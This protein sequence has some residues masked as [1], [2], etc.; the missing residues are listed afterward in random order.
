MAAR[1]GYL[2]E[3]IPGV[4]DITDQLRAPMKKNLLKTWAVAFREDVLPNLSVERF[5]CLYSNNNATRPST[6][7]RL[8]VGALI[9]QQYLGL[10]DDE[11][12][13][14]MQFD[15]RVIY[16]LGTGSFEEPPSAIRP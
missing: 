10:T 3:S 15:M 4:F 9:I 1:I 8:V 13:E 11:M 7:I 6:P 16:A 2:Y 5:G 12:V 14:A